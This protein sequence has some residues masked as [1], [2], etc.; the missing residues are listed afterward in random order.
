[1]HIIHLIATLYN[2]G[3]ATVSY[4]DCKSNSFR[5]LQG[6][7][8]GSILSPHLYNIYTKNLLNDISLNC[9]VGTSIYGIYS[10]IIAYADDIILMSSTLSG[11]QKLINECQVYGQSND[12]KI[13][14][15]K[16]MFTV[17]GKN[18]INNTYIK[19]NDS[20]I[21]LQDKLKHLGFLWNNESNK[22]NISTLYN[23]NINERIVKFRAVASSLITNGIRF[24]HPYTIVHLFN[25]LAVPT[26][27]YGLE[28][29]KLNNELSNRLDIIGR[30]VLKCLFNISKFSKNYLHSFFNIDQ[31]SAVI[32]R[33]KLNLFIR[34]IK[35][36]YNL[37]NH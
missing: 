5:L 35:K 17:S 28:L 11:L 36:S 21:N 20:R 9:S 4:Q 10:G 19:I 27:T 33:N 13:N 24:C 34:L 7:R 22:S 23:L 8:Q 32:I 25:S 29:C 6:V 15:P 31:I 3:S 30:S 14:A 1:L 26:L 37:R 18:P 16:T 12:I 2:S